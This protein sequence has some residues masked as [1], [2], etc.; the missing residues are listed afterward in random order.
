MSADAAARL[1]LLRCDRCATPVALADAD[2]VACPSCGAAVAIP[3][4]HRA[5][6]ADARRDSEARF[7]AHELYDQLG[8]PPRAL[9]TLGVVMDPSGAIKPL[10][11]N[12]HLWVR[13]LAWYY[14]WTA[15]VLGPAV[16]FL[17][18]IVG[19]NLSLRAVGALRH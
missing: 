9:R 17:V 18:A 4:G 5:A 7:A 2:T 13:M 10:R 15:V 1:E 8:A 6:L 3:A 12:R 11:R 19:V 14:G 16:M